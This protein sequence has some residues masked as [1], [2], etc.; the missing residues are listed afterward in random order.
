MIGLI[1]CNN[2]YVSCERVFN[3]S[4]HG[5]P[6]VVL[7]NNDGCIISRSDEAKA[8]GIPMGASVHEVKQLLEKYKVIM[9]SSNYALYG[10][11]SNRVVATLQELVPELEVYSIDEMFLDFSEFNETQL[12]ALARQVVREVHKNTGIPVSLGIAPTKALAKMANRMA[13]KMP[14]GEKVFVIENQ[15][16]AIEILRN[17]PVENIWGI[18]RQHATFLKKHNVLTGLDFILANKGWVQ[19]S[20]SVVGLRLWR[21]LNGLPSTLLDPDTSPKKNICTS[22]SFGELLRDYSLIEQAVANFAARCAEK[23]RGQGSCAGVLTISLNTNSF[24]KELPQYHN[25]ATMRLAVS[26]NSTILLVQQALRG[27]KAIFKEGYQYKKAGVLVS[28]LIPQNR[29]QATLF[30]DEQSEKHGKLMEVMDA[31]NLKHGRDKLRLSSQG[32]DRRWKS[33]QAKLSKGFTTDMRE[34]LMVKC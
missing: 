22:R 7:S 21:E 8:L 23:L 24:R 26:S 15:E 27:L 2:F 32:Y 4:L 12:M 33:K 13:K 28:E 31:M 20:M 17:F 11:M 29:V 16:R 6:V 14:T 1:D 25:S 18:G 9:H 34:V 19:A 30:T 10:D 3:P 5:K